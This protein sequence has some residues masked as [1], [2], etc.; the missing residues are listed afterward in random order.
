MLSKWAVLLE[1]VTG[2][3]QCSVRAF[4]QKCCSTEFSSYNKIVKAYHFLGCGQGC[5]ICLGP[6]IP[7]REKYTKGP[8]NYTKRLCIIPNGH[9]LSLS[10]IHYTK[11]PQNIPTFSILWPSIIY[12]NWDFWF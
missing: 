4:T 8:K 1:M 2:R 11:W 6:N 9:K 3:I 10:A 5:Q 12:P 7:K